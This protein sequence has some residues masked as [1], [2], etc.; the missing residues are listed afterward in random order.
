VIARQP[1][2]IKL[3]RVV[4]FPMSYKIDGSLHVD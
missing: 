3:L 2:V 1:P 4:D